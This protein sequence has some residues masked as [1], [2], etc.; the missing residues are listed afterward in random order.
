VG[1]MNGHKNGHKALYYT[2][3]NQ[4]GGL[5]VLSLAQLMRTAP[6]QASRQYEV[7]RT[8]PLT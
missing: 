6:I 5:L 7:R 3:Q 8:D 1:V 2:H 4:F